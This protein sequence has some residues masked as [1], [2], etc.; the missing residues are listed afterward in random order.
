MP[1]GGK[2]RGTGRPKGGGERREPTKTVRVPVS[3]AEKIPEL[4]KK[5][6]EQESSDD[7]QLPGKQHEERLPLESLAWDAFEAFCLDFISRYLKTKECHHYG[8][9]GDNQLGIDLVAE[10][11][12]GEKWAFQCKQWQKFNRSDAEKVIQETTYPADRYVLLLS[13]EA[14]RAVRDVIKAQPGWEVWDVRDISRKVRELPIE[15]ARRLVRDH[16]HP[17]W[18]NAFLGVSGL[19]PFVSPEDFFHDALNSNEPFNH[20]WEL[21]GRDKALQSLNEFLESSQKQVAILPGRGGIGKTKLLHAFAEKFDRSSLLVRFVEE[22]VPITTENS[23]NLPVTPCVVV[24][25]DAHRRE[26]DLSVLLALVRQ[27]SNIKLIL[28]SRPHAVEHLKVR[29]TQAG[30]GSGQISQFDEL[31]ELSRDEVKALARQA[32]GSEYA[33]FADQLASL[34]KDCPLVTVVGGRLLAE[35]KIPLRLLER[36]EDFQHDVLKRFYDDVLTGKISHRIEPELCKRLLEL[37]AAV[38]P[39]RL[40]KELFQQVAAEF[41]KIERRQLVSSIGILEQSGVLLRRGYSLRITPDVLSDRI[42]HEACLTPQ[43]EP[44]GYAQEVFEKFKSI[45]PAEVLRNLAE[46]DWRISYVSGEETGLLA[47]IWR[48]IREEFEKASYSGRCTLLDLLEKVAYYQPEPTLELVEVAMRPATTPE[49]ESLS[50]FYT[51]AELLLKLPRLLQQISYTMDYLYLPRCCDLLWE[52]AREDRRELNP[53]PEHPIRV[54]TDLAK[55]DFLHK[56]LKFNQMVLRTVSRWLKKPDAHNHQYS[57]LNVIAPLLSKT[58]C[59]NRYDG[60]TITYYSRPVVREET[61]VIREQALNLIADCLNSNQL[62][63]ILRGLKSLEEALQE[64]PR[65]RDGKR[66]EEQCKQW[67]PEQLKIL[68][69]IKELVEQTKE[70]LIHLEVIKVLHWH[71]HLGYAESVRQKALEIINLI[72][73]TYELRL[74]GSL[75]YTGEL[76]WLINNKGKIDF[77]AFESNWSNWR[78]GEKRVK[79]LHLTVVEEFLRRYPDA[80]EEVQVLNRELRAIK[81]SDVEPKAESFLASLREVVEPSYVAEI[82]ESLVESPDSPLAAYLSL[83]LYKVRKFDVHPAITI[84]QRAVDTGS[85]ILCG[86]LAEKY[87]DWADNLQSQDIKIINKLLAHNDVKVRKDAIA[88]LGRMRYSQ[89]KLV[90][91]MAL[92]V[93]IDSRTELASELYR[94]F[95]VNNDI[96]INTLSDQQLDILLTKLEHVE[97]ITECYVSKFISDVSK[98]VPRAVVQLL[99]KRIEHYGKEGYINYYPLLDSR[100]EPKLKG[101]AESEEYEDILRDIRNQALTQANKKF[102]LAKLFK[103]VSL[104][105]TPTSLKVLDEWINSR[106]LEKVQAASYLL[107]DV[108]QS[109]VFTHIKFVSEILEQAYLLEDDC[110]R[111]VSNNLSYRIIMRARC[112]TLGEP[113]PEDIDLQANSLAV[114]KK[115][116]K[117]TPA[118][119]F[120]ESLAKYARANIEEDLSLEEELF[121]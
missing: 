89:P 43:G 49:S 3:F 91:R 30:I 98:R 42:L 65:E 14:S 39:I 56:P 63:V 113:Y 71:I 1:R 66:K 110:Y 106:E 19:A 95:D 38:A 25:D 12:N 72:P 86:S 15:V 76:D 59:S 27:R 55:Y 109:F 93:E 97:Y 26:E 28:S 60:L 104:D 35:R 114:G 117:G 85:S 57:P 94:F 36:N 23:D 11:E 81:E 102:W 84:A 78:E 69:F 83:L 67:V 100:V 103:E 120:Y 40:T 64:L 121:E 2:R 79:A 88:S 116:S 37:I 7:L 50:S 82:C 73:D 74:T 44:T 46:L 80:D 75:A 112:G 54:L 77:I 87:Y 6:Q 24:L 16:F 70:P 118:R 111:I 18:Q 51:H 41:L 47:D 92:S 58:A 17:E 90:S 107:C 21:V 33:H 22:G 101:L 13:R 119:K 31:K 62:K 20:A 9:Q 34:T 48:S 32:L 108:P 29:L 45:C 115:F 53:Y 105:F 8:T 52:L 68:E 4:L 61:Y 10:L 5:H 96:K 99:L